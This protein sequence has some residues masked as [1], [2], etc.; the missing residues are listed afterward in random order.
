MMKV[1]ITV[2][3][4]LIEDRV[5]AEILSS[6]ESEGE[7]VCMPNVYECFTGYLNAKLFRGKASRAVN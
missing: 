7:T 3:V 4:I 5:V 1:K 2:W 6:Q